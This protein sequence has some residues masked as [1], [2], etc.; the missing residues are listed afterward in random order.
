M[1][2][3]NKCEQDLPASEFY[4]NRGSILTV[5]KVCNDLANRDARLVRTYG[6]TLDDYLFIAEAQ[7][8]RCRI[9]RNPP[10]EGWWL[11]VDHDHQTGLLRGLLCTRC[12]S[13]L[14]NANDSTETLKRAIAYLERKQWPDDSNSLIL[15]SSLTG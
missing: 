3:C 7:N 10:A 13:L 2:T 5:C 1:P 12:N 4:K 9:C 14:A 11:A 15:P 6:I 8:H